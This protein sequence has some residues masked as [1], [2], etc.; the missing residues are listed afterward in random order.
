MES[1]NAAGVGVVAR[2]LSGEVIISS[3]EFPGQCTSVNKA[4]FGGCLAGLY[5]HMTLN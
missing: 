5:I 4:E 1:L 2:N 3:W